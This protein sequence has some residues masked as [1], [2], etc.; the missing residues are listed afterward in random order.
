MMK[1]YEDVLLSKLKQCRPLDYFRFKKQLEPRIP[2][3]TDSDLIDSPLTAPGDQSDVEDRQWR[4][5]RR[6]HDAM[7]IIDSCKEASGHHVTSNRFKSSVR[8]PIAK[9]KKWK[10]AWTNEFKLPKVELNA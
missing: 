7:D 9:F 5:T 10:S 8:N 4:L 3:P 1:C 6:L 2:T